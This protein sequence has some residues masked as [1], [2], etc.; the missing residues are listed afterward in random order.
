MCNQSFALSFG[1]TSLL[2]NPVTYKAGDD[3]SSLSQV[4]SACYRHVFGNTMPMESE[5]LESS[6][7][8]LKHGN[9]TVRE[10][11]RSLAKST[12][13]SS[14]FY[15][16]VTPHR[17]VE[18]AIKHLLG[19][20]PI[21][22]AE[23]STEV[24]RIAH[25][26][27]DASID[28]LIDSEE[29]ENSFGD[30]TAPYIRT[31]NSPAGSPQSAFNR[32]AALEQNFAGSD[33]AIG[34]MSQL[35][36]SLARNQP[37]TI[38]VPAQ[39]YRAQSSGGFG[40]TATGR[41]VYAPVRRSSSDGGDS[42]PLRGD[43]YV[44]FGLGQRSQEIFQRVPGDTPDQIQGLIRAAY[45]QVMGN[46][47]L[48]ESERVLSAESKFAEGYLSTRELVRAIACSP[49][50]RRRFFESN[51]PYRFVELNFKHLLGR[52]P[53]SQAELSEHIQ[54]LAIQ[55]Y[56]AE[57]SSYLD[58]SE[59]QLCFGEYTVP[60]ARIQT[61]NGRDQIGFNRHLA[62][63]QGYS[64]SDTVQ[65]SSSLVT[66]LGA[67][68]L[69]SGWSTTTVRLNRR[70]AFSGSVDP[71]TKRYRIAVQAQPAGGRQRTPNASYLVS[72][73]DMTTQLAY[74]HRR[75]GRIISITEVA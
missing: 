36:G 52:A 37:I 49:E 30:H 51:A 63:V 28:A 75:G 18:L 46:P 6:E 50:Y 64:S 17:C 5:R 72:G 45:R 12:F 22:E 14:R 39:V 31:W 67:K 38:R 53:A 1:A 56:E 73:K 34:S 20:P 74:I 60:F 66:S 35:L 9:L 10:F 23:V 41:S 7:S 11:V 21:D 40:G 27:F 32:I 33:S 15:E 2:T 26:G 69:P 61:E 8:Q 62:L 54:R 4:I 68:A 29:Y 48:M 59:Y 44:G 55:G 65:S 24:A 57:I 47:H 16:A 19:R 58:G 71:T 3:E 43:L 13:Y 42:I 25:A 70:S